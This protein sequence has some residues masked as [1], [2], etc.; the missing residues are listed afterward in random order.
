[1]LQVQASV[2]VQEMIMCPK[3]LGL[4]V[5]TSNWDFFGVSTIEDPKP[6]KLADYP[7]ASPMNSACIHSCWR[8]CK[9]QSGRPSQAGLC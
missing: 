4:V 8:Q 1:M 6:R 9:L 2:V 7:S 3:G 5:M